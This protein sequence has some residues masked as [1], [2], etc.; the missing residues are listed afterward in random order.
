MSKCCSISSINTVS[1][2]STVNVACPCWQSVITFRTSGSVRNDSSTC[3]ATCNSISCTEAPGRA[4]ITTACLTGT[5]G[6]SSFG[7]PI[8]LRSP[9]MSIAAINDHINVGRSTRYLMIFIIKV[10]RDWLMIFVEALSLFLRYG[11]CL[12]QP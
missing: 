12:H 9:A 11:V 3:C 4:T 1:S 2:N 7:I 8:K 6:S 5:T 10:L